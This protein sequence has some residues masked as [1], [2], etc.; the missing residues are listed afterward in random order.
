MVYTSTL[1]ATDCQSLVATGD[2]SF[3]NSTKVGK[4][5]ITARSLIVADTRM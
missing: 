4:G 5:Y 1:A 3:V 2:D